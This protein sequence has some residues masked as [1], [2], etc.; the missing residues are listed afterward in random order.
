MYFC[1]YFNEIREENDDELDDMVL[2]FK[3]VI[4]QLFGLSQLVMYGFLID[5][6]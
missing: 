2:V 6:G 5:S 4:I 3:F 1:I